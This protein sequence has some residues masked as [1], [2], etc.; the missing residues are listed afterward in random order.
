MY[1]NHAFLGKF[2]FKF[3][4]RYNKNQGCLV[5]FLKLKIGMTKNKVAKKKL[6]KGMTKNKVAKKKLNKGMA[7]IK[8]VKK[9]LKIS[10]TKTRLLRKN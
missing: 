6:N 4:Q 8:A 1:K 5:N 9:K 10:M 2:F 3:E 7:K